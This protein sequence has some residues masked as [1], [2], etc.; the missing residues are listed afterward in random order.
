MK[1]KKK[2]GIVMFLLGVILLSSSF[3]IKS[4]VEAGQEKIANVE[5]QTDLGDKLLSL[6]PATKEVG[7]GLTGSIKEK[8]KEGKEQI[9]FYTAVAKSLEIGGIILIVL[10]AGIMLLGKKNRS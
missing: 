7:K 8:V 5:S 6:T 2:W 4:Q 10:G 3:Y 1:A 9:E